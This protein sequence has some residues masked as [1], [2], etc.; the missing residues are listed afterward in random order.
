MLRKS[1]RSQAQLTEI[2]GTPHW[3]WSQPATALGIESHDKVTFLGITYG[4]TI[5]KSVKDSWAGILRS[6]RA[7][8]RKAY[9]RTLCLAQRVQYVHLCLL[10][11]IWYLAQI[12]PLTKEHVQQLTT[13]CTWFIWQGAIFRVPVSTL[14]LPN[15]QGGGWVLA[16]IDAKSKTF[17]YAR[18]WFLCTKN[19]SITK[20]LM[21][22][23]NLTGPIA[24]PRNVHSLPTGISYIRHYALDMAY[25]APPGPQKKTTQKFKNRIY[26]VPLTMASTGNGTSK[27]RITR[28]YIAIAWQRVWTNVH[29][30]GLSD[31]IKST[32]YA[33]IHEI[34]P[35]NECSAAIHLTTTTSCLRCGATDTLLHRLIACEEGP[36][37]WTWTKTRIAP[38]LRIHPKHIPGEWTLRPIFHHWPPPKAGGDNMDRCPSSSI[39]SPDTATPLSY[40]LHGLP[41]TNPLERVPPST[42]DTHSRKVPGCAIVPPSPS[43]PDAFKAGLK[44]DSMAPTYLDSK[45]FHPL[46]DL[47]RL[48]VT[49]CRVWH[50]RPV[51]NMSQPVDSV[52][53]KYK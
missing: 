13:V 14:Q 30:T 5:T 25:V 41:A 33:A 22:K 7:Q 35:T 6:V 45:H 17:L 9:A 51:R 15:E 29:T 31:P 28:K 48:A 37:I 16:N 42:Q 8:A 38:I 32:R 3:V 50:N 12:L 18:L 52:T 47:P 43:A 20:T 26:G 1:H 36:V 44:G 10:A 53:C 27:L 23:W 49:L 19:C 21:R 39:S 24:N 2:E 40:L 46:K 4:T 11:K 34:I